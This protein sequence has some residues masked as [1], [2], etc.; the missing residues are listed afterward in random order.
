MFQV[1]Q[2]VRGNYPFSRKMQIENKIKADYLNQSFLLADYT[3]IKIGE[4]NHYNWSFG[5]K[6]W[7]IKSIQPQKGFSGSREYFVVMSICKSDLLKSMRPF[8]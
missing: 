7:G 6:N 5:E 2:P 3:V 8:R 1:C 4:L